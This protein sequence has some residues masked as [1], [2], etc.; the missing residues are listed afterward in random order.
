MRRATAGV[1]TARSAAATATCRA[2]SPPGAAVRRAARRSPA[3]TTRARGRATSATSGR[4]HA[5]MRPNECTLVS[6]DARPST[7]GTTAGTRSRRAA[8]RAPG[9]CHAATS[10]PRRAIRARARHAPRQS[11][12]CAGAAP[13]SAA[14]S[15]RA[16]RW[17]RATPASRPFCA[18]PRARRSDT[19]ASTSADS[20]AARWPRSPR[21]AKSAA[22]GRTP[23]SWTPTAST[24]AHCAAAASL[25]AGATAAS[26]SA[27][28]AP[29]GRACSPRLRRSLAPV[30]ARCWSRLFRAACGSSAHIR[31]LG[32]ARRAATPRCRTAATRPRRRVRLAY[33]SRAVPVPAASTSCRQ[34]RAA[35]LRCVAGV[36]VASCSPVACTAAIVCATRPRRAARRAHTCVGSHVRSVATPARC[37]AMRRSRARSRSHALRWWCASAPVAT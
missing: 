35:A 14:S 27:T 18:T 37:R 6:A 3:G 34:C 24:H 4:R 7:G 36:S 17:R 5:R 2:P 11:S 25:P 31:A 19:A 21:S 10:A 15:A 12:R 16:S 32:R 22:P 8:C 1:S 9:A 30:A 20:A 29:V 28:G 26:A 33:T 13:R 23:C